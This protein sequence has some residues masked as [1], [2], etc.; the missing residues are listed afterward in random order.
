E[1][2]ILSELVNRKFHR[3]RSEN[4]ARG[5]AQTIQ[6]LRGEIDGIPAYAEAPVERGTRFPDVWQLAV[7]VEREIA[8]GDWHEALRVIEVMETGVLNTPGHDRWLF[9]DIL[10]RKAVVLAELGDAEA[11]EG[12]IARYERFRTATRNTQPF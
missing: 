7:S 4:R 9:R 5:A 10:P 11:L 1:H 8:V 6:V 12:V 3:D 2:G